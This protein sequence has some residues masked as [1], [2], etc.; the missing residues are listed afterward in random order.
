MALRRTPMKR[1]R[2]TQIPREVRE[3][4]RL[5][6]KGCVGPRAGMLGPCWGGLEQDH[7][8]ASHATGMKSASE[9]GNLVL[10]CSAH[11]EYKTNHG[12]E[13]RPLLLAYLER[14]E[15]PL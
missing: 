8:R 15:V 12:R 5:R 1:S 4:V 14:M 11:H 9:P 7:V 13:I 3:Y 2:G 6:D 10:L